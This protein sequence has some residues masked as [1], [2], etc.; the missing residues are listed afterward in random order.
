MAYRLRLKPAPLAKLAESPSQTIT[1]A[2]VRQGDSFL[3]CL[4][5][6]RAVN[7]FRLAMLLIERSDHGIRAHFQSQQKVRLSGRKKEA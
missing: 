5:L 2:S 7:L 6:Q 3:T 4:I 1:F